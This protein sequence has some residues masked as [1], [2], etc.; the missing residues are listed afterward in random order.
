V[1]AQVVCISRAT[2]AEGE[3]VG[4]GVAERLGFRYVDNEVIEQAAEWAE[5]APGFVAD[6]ERRKPFLARILGTIVEETSAP[7]LSSGVPARSLPSDSDL[8]SLIGSVL[9]SFAEQGSVVIVAHA[10]S[11]ALAEAAVLRVLVTASPGTRAGRVAA[12]E[13]IDEDKA[14]RRVASD[15]A[16]RADYLKR[17]YRIDRE[18]PTHYDLVVNTDV[19]TPE[20]AAEIVVAAAT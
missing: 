9:E 19:L 11:F 8:R 20:R 1:A 10:A 2:G 6:V 4:R 7:R 17:F 15:D 18:L 5:L 3:T 16:A 13:G 14:G 12:A